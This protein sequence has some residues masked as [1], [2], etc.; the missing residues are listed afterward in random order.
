MRQRFITISIIV[1]VLFTCLAGGSVHAQG[2]GENIA[3]TYPIQEVSVEPGD[4]IAQDRKSNNFRTARIANSREMFG[5]V[6][7]R[8]LI[9]FRTNDNHVPIIRSGQTEVKI[10]VIGGDIEIGDMITSSR[11]RGYGRKA[12]STDTYKLGK[13]LEA[14][15][16]SD[17]TT[18]TTLPTRGTSTVEVAAGKI[19]IDVN[20]APIGS[21]PTGPRDDT[22]TSSDADSTPTNAGFLGSIEPTSIVKYIVAAV[23]AVSSVY[24]SFRYFGSNLSAG[25]SSVGRNPMAKGTIMKMVSMNVAAI[26]LISLAGIG[27]SVML[28]LL[29]I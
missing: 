5:V 16:A 12:T 10:T 4:I 3:V 9:V 19:L 14:F 28:L 21:G 25:V 1:S 17:A 18:T 13:A 2:P 7:K 11:V 27:L 24:S 15:R 6:A 23:V 29:P 20:I 8:P 22:A 26:V